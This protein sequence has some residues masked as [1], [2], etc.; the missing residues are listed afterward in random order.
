MDATVT[1]SLVQYDELKSKIA[2]LEQEL[3]IVKIILSQERLAAETKLNNLK[4]FELHVCYDGNI[5]INP[6]ND[7][8]SFIDKE[9]YQYQNTHEFSELPEMFMWDFGEKKKNIEMSEDEGSL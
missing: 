7:A 4:P 9:A 8:K 6:G 2:E 5:S 3:N 1:M